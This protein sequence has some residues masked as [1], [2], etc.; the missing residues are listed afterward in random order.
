MSEQIAKIAKEL[1]SVQLKESTQKI[2]HRVCGCP[3]S[4]VF[5]IIG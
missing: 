3:T 5:M 4:C 1:R 2:G